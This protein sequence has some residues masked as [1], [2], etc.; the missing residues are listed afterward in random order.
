MF[1]LAELPVLTL[2]LVKTTRWPFSN[3]NKNSLITFIV[4]IKFQKIYL[5]AVVCKGDNV[6]A[7]PKMRSAS[8]A[9][10]GCTYL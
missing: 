9:P 4:L 6:V 7:E 10:F 2:S 8:G 1:Y 3:K 5:L